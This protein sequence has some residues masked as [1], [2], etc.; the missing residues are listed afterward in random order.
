MT[1]PVK[2][3]LGPAG[4]AFLALNFLLTKLLYH[5]ARLIRFPFYCRGRRFMFFGS[6]LT[7]GRSCRF[8][9]WSLD[10]DPLHHNLFKIVIEDN[11]HI[12]DRVQIASACG[13]KIGSNTLI[14]SNVFISDHDHGLASIESV[15]QS[16]SS[17]A[18]SLSSVSIGKSCWIGQNVC[19]LKGVE[20]GDHCIVAAGAVVTR[21][22]PS[23]SVIGGVPAKLLKSLY[24][25]HQL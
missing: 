17:R 11:V 22:F 25:P 8:D 4:I 14:A 12:G 1:N 7:L 23:F 9:A 5:K 6:G 10:G 19:I 20:L 16:P 13:L 18:L 24:D 3:P 15:L 21:S 2:Y